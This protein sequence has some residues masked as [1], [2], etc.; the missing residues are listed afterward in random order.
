MFC[1]CPEINLK[2]YLPNCTNRK[3]TLSKE[4][5]LVRTKTKP[6]F[7]TCYQSTANS[8]ILFKQFTFN[9]TLY[10]AVYTSYLYFQ[11]TLSL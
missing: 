6:V 7:L 11:D 1:P 3:L 8:L 10:T 9:K 5:K 4:I 2:Q